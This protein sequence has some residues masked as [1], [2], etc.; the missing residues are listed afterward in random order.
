MLEIRQTETYQKWF[1]SLKDKKT[2]A[3]INFASEGF[4]LAILAM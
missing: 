2:R 4:R 1:S 3:R